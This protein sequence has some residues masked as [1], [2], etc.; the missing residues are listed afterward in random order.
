MDDEDV[1]KV[2]LNNVLLKKIVL[3]TS[4]IRSML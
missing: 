1:K 3:K 4:K 2:F